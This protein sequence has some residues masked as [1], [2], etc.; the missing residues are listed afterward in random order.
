MRRSPRACA[1]CSR[2]SAHW[3]STSRL[4]PPVR[5]HEPVP[6]RRRRPDRAVRP[7]AGAGAIDEALE[8]VGLAGG[9]PPGTGLLPRDAAAARD[10]P[11]RCCDSPRLLVLDEPTNGLDPQGIHEIRDLLL[12]M[13]AAGTTLFVSS[14]LLAEVRQPAPASACSTAAGWSCRTTWPT[15][16]PRPAARSC[17]RPTPIGRPPCWTAASSTATA[18]GSSSGPRT[19]RASSSCWCAAGSGSARSASSGPR[20]RGGRPRGHLG[21]ERS[22]RG[23]GAAVIRVEISKRCASLGTGYRSG[24]VPAALGRRGA[25]CASRTSRRG[26]VRGRRSSNAVL[27]N[28][29]LFP[30]AA[31]GIVL[32]LFL[33][34]AVAVIA[35]DSI[36]G[37]ASG[38]TLRYLLVR[39]VGRT[40]AHRQ[41]RRRPGV[42]ACRRHRR[43][44][45]RVRRR[46]PP[47]RLGDCTH[48][49][50]RD[51]DHPGRP[52]PGTALVVLY[53]AWS[54]VGVA[55]VALL[56]STLPTPR[57]AQ[58]S[59]PWPCSC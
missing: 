2:T 48:L 59:A 37:E 27:T 14:H 54:M 17:A 29:A 22:R 41:A 31:L 28:G 35:G 32:P 26:P 5:A 16:A 44:R 25:S 7:R 42:P 34:V 55:A 1:A 39:P 43:G 19:P 20:F 40:R 11:L 6:G 49:T 21:R 30:A 12:A 51:S 57:S 58:R 3:S 13:N 18:T 15:C 46:H 50:V 45:D 52:G 24:C 10:W 9:P 33:P 4:R 23:R 53:V 38:G 47:V 56:L 36:A 8:Q